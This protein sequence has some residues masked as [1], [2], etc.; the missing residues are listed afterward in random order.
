MESDR[1]SQNANLPGLERLGL[2]SYLHLPQDTGA[3]APTPSETTGSG[4][5][6]PTPTST[7]TPASSQRYQLKRQLRRLHSAGPAIGPRRGRSYLGTQGYME[8]RARPRRDTGSDGKPVWS[9][10]VE[11]AFQQGELHYFPYQQFANG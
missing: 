9:D 11:D 5:T 3:D 8:Y 4:P 10:E 6:L 2:R 7:N 1:Q